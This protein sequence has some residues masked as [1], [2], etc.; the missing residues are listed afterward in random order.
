MAPDLAQQEETPVGI[1]GR[2]Q[3][4]AAAAPGVEDVVRKFVTSLT[5]RV[6]LVEERIENIRDRIELVEHSLIDKHKTSIKQIK[7]MH[8]E[9]RVLRGDVE[10]TKT[11]IERVVK[12]LD[13]FAS[14]EEVKVLRRYVE[15]W[16]PMSYV[17]RSE[18]KAIVRNILKEEGLIK[19]VKE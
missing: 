6:R 2:P 7:N 9:M 19:E 17:N 13:A 16:Q 11:L 1:F 14:N 10:E 8:D 18:A 12:R 4:P 5:S 3:A 15:L